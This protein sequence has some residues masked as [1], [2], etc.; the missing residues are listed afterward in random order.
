MVHVGA[1]HEHEVCV[2]VCVCARVCACI[3]VC[4]CVRA[5]MCVCA[6]VCKQGKF[7]AASVSE[8]VTDMR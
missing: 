5:R 1:M 7:A 4:T 3:C 8:L 6:C 2:R